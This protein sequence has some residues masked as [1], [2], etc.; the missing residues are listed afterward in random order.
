[1]NH[2]SLSADTSEV[3][4]RTVLGWDPVAR[5]AIG[6]SCIMKRSGIVSEEKAADALQ[7]IV[8]F[9]PNP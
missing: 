5:R 7:V 9:I 8:S 2:R 1:M 4:L 3:S 6:K